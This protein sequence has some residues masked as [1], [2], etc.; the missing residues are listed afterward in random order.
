MAVPARPDRLW[1]RF[2]YFSWY[3]YLFNYY[4]LSSKKD[5]FVWPIWPEVNCPYFHTPGKWPVIGLLQDHFHIEAHR[6]I[7][8]Y[9]PRLRLRPI[10]KCPCINLYIHIFPDNVFLFMSLYFYFTRCIMNLIIKLRCPSSCI[11]KFNRFS[12]LAISPNLI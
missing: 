3:Y 11:C 10:W 1:Q 6:P 7:C 9:G 8:H 2:V 4:I 5:I 12:L